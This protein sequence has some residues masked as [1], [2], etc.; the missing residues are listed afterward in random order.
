MRKKL[1]T[2]DKKA[3]EGLI[4]LSGS[5]SR[6]ADVRKHRL[7]RRARAQNSVSISNATEAMNL[8]ASGPLVHR[9]GVIPRTSG[10][11]LDD[12]DLGD[13][14]NGVLRDGGRHTGFLVEK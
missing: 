4:N 14:A 11:L 5:G 9:V 6:S 13:P 1:K 2:G 10:L 8:R 7:F 3:Q 12:I